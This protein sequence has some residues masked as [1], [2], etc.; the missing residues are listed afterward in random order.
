MADTKKKMIQAKELRYGNYVTKDGETFKINNIYGSS[1]L[2]DIVNNNNSCNR[3]SI[4]LGKI[5][6]IPLTEEILLK[7]GFENDYTQQSWHHRTF[8]I[9]DFQIEEIENKYFYNRLNIASLH[10]LQNLYFALTVQ[11]LTI[12]F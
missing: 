2:L 11:E 7:C 1:G 3:V 6:G 10:Q 5:Q 4:V 8:I 9:N 12:N